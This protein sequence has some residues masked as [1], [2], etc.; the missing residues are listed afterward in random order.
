[1]VSVK[2]IPLLAVL[3]LLVAV[4]SPSRPDPDRIVAS[5]SSLFAQASAQAINQT[6]PDSYISFL[7]LDAR[8]GELLASRWNGAEQPI[9]LGSLAKPF[10]ALAYG[11][12]NGFHYPAHTCRGTQTGCW[13]PGGHGDVDLTSAIT[14]SCNSYFRVLTQDLEAA[15]VSTTAHRFGIE[16]PERGTSGIEL[17]G[18]GPHW[19][20]S[21]LHMAHAYLALLA[22][23][24]N[25]TVAQI[26]RGMERSAREGTAA[27]VDR[28]LQA[29]GA[30]A[31]TGTAPCTHVRHAPGDGF[32]IAL[33]PAD[34]P[35]V[36]LLVRVHGVPG[37]RAARTAGE[38]L[39]RIR[40]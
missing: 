8:T 39:R 2:Q 18:L 6:F 5:R 23:R 13:R 28:V 21:P 29:G 34:E 14:Y 9:P 26:L 1:M 30:L 17:A 31:K 32:A 25:P 33:A 37:S 20:I 11:E 24:D 4:P 3:V 38:M 40:E 27:E 22:N 12:Q 10:A 7:L 36:L 19:R 35:R 16:P 15:D